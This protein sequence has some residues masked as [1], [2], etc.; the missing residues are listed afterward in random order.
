M[1]FNFF[2]PKIARVST[3]FTGHYIDVKVFY[4]LL[5]DK[6]P[7]VSFIGELDTSKVF[8]FVQNTLRDKVA[9]VYQHNYFDHEKQQVFFNNTVFVLKNARM[10]EAGNNFCHVLYTIKKYDWAQEVI[11][12]L[13]QFRLAENVNDNN[14]IGFARSHTL[15]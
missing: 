1:L 8:E 15:T 11:K 10:I 6:V 2:K 4:T 13:A 7:C 5:F 3:L 14:V 12:E 9:G